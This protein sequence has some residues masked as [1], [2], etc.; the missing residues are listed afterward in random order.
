MR[1]LPILARVIQITYGDIALEAC[2]QFASLFLI[3]AK[4]LAQSAVE[5]H[6]I[7]GDE[8]VVVFALVKD[9]H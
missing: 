4:L 5:R 6:R 1:G 2:A 3:G 7:A 8:A 9:Q